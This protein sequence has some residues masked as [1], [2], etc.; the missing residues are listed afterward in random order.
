MISQNNA[1][2][3]HRKYIF[4]KKYKSLLS[5]KLIR[6]LGNHRQIKKNVI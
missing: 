1:R 2:N 3:S 5:E 6:I 4:Y